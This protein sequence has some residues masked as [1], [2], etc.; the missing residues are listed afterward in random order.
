M[1][2]FNTCVIGLLE[3]ENK[4]EAKSEDRIA[5][6]VPNLMKDSISQTTNNINLTFY[7]A[8]DLL[9]TET[10]VKRKLSVKLHTH[11]HT[12]TKRIREHI[13]RKT[14]IG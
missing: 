12:R 9:S 3:E 1:K 4:V 11:T 10:P 7:P 6:N 14:R 5:K 8:K 2:G 13:S